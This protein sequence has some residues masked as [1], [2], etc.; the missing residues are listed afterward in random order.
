[1]YLIEKILEKRGGGKKDLNF[2]MSTNIH[3]MAKQNVLLNSTGNC[4]QYHVI[5]HNEKEYITE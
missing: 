3:R 5:K 4:T 2:G 1:M